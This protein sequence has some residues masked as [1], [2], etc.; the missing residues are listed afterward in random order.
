MIKY[1][2]IWPYL[3]YTIHS[4]I[5]G[6]VICDVKAND[7][8]C[9]MLLK[10]GSPILIVL[11]YTKYYNRFQRSV[12]FFVYQLQSRDE[13]FSYQQLRSLLIKISNYNCIFPLYVIRRF[14]NKFLITVNT[15]HRIYLFRHSI[16]L[17]GTIN[18]FNP[19]WSSFTIYFRSWFWYF[20][21]QT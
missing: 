21:K 16:K 3:A 4:K 18:C 2:V 5:F 6:Y 1:D 8:I 11:Y 12:A 13:V 9:F 15:F 10:N 20:I 7:R 14:A 17:F 19:R